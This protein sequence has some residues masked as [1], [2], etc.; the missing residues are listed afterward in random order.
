MVQRKRNEAS[1][2]PQ[3]IDPGAQR[4]CTADCINNHISAGAVGQPL[5]LVH[6]LVHAG[7]HSMASTHTHRQVDFPLRARDRDDLLSAGENREAGMKETCGSLSQDDDGIIARDA[8]AH[9]R[10]PY[11]RERLDER[12][13]GKW[14]VR[15]ERM[16]V[17]RRQANILAERAFEFTTNNS[18]IAA[19]MF[20]PAPAT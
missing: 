7:S 8:G 6:C 10:V 4:P 9:L 2:R 12:C 17:T 3:H 1:A 11:G 15:R 13:F 18:G 19:Q 14:Q 16:E 5:N 20:V